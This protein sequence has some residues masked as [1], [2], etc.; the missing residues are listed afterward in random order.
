MTSGAA[1]TGLRPR[2][3]DLWATLNTM[4]LISRLLAALGAA[5]PS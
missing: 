3:S 1:K 2:Y 5:L 4:A